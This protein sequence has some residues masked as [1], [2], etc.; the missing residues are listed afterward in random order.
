M[1][2]KI[3]KKFS[4]VERGAERQMRLFTACGSAELEEIA[5][6]LCYA[7]PLARRQKSGFSGKSGKTKAD[8]LGRRNSWKK[9]GEKEDEEKEPASKQWREHTDL[10]LDLD[11]REKQVTCHTSALSLAMTD[12][13]CREAEM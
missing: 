8:Y 11:E 10:G 9:L 5:L 4:G 12:E 6:W 13:A 1:K 7:G 3:C 2:K